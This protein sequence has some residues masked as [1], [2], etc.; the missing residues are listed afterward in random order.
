MLFRSRK[1]CV[2][3]D[4]LGLTS[5]DGLCA[6][7]ASALDSYV[8]ERSL[9][10]RKLTPWLR[11]IGLD[12]RDIQISLAGGPLRVQLSP[13]RSATALRHLLER[14][15]QIG[16]REPLAVFFDEFQETS[17]R[18]SASDARHVLGVLRSMIQHQSDVAYYFA[19]SAKGS[20]TA[21]FTREG[22]PFF[23]GAQLIEVT[24]I[25][26]AQFGDFLTQQFERSDRKSVV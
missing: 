23:E 1:P 19:G 17:D 24:P 22:A 3:I 5:V 7:I 14:V 12:L 25:P 4:L 15:E 10:T 6:V 18:L 8:R 11:E 20:F 26:R 16:K 13:A 2:V 9:V 21:L